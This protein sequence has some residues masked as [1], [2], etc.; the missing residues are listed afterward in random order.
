MI[1]RTGLIAAA[2]GLAALA[3]CQL[4]TPAAT[5]SHD[6]WEAYRQ[7]HA[8]DFAPADH[9]TARS[10][11]PSPTTVELQQFAALHNDAVRAA[12]HRW[13]AQVQQIAQARSL[14][15]P[16]ISYT[17][18]IVEV[19]TRVG[20]QHQAVSLSQ[21]VPWFGKLDL[22][23]D[24][25]AQQATAA[26]WDFQA[27]LLELQADVRAA[28]A[29]YRYLHE[30]QAITQD[31]LRLL[32]QVEQLVRTRYTNAQASQ[33]DLLRA[34]TEIGKLQD[35]LASLERQLTPT[36]AGI[37][38]LLGRDAAE[39]IGLADAPP[40][41]PLAIDEAAW[42]DQLA[43]DSPA[44]KALTHQVDASDRGVDLAKKAYFPDVTVSGTWIDTG[45]RT[46]PMAPA[47]SGQDAVM[48]M[49]SLNLPIWYDKLRAGVRQAEHRQRLL[50]AQ[51]VGRHR[52]LVT[53]LARDCWKLDDA[54][55]RHDLYQR[56]LLPKARDAMRAIQQDYTGGKSTFVDLMDAQRT[57]LDFQLVL[58]RA[59]ADAA[60][61]RAGIH[62]LIGPV[63]ETGNADA[64]P[65]VVKDAPDEP[66][67]K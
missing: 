60:L 9:A 49:V 61:A 24:Q 50:E 56:V 48:A 36:R 28:H 62:R 7:R 11:S 21:T 30:A 34:Q 66:A 27:R 46:G 57:L 31:N 16:R 23:G 63:A 67:G 22:A 64:P 51:R 35:R 1:R 14:P 33:P 58:A 20:P 52:Q 2:V 53:R 45:D 41:E 25:A 8:A 39:P 3:G 37:N 4:T 13:Q 29:E 26:W 38:E 59:R 43:K 6:S 40:Y 10:L 47:D 12:F 54:Q 44:L 32:Q 42:R 17:Y 55:R 15:D 5:R 18:Y 19:E 65:G